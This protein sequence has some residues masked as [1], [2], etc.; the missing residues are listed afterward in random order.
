MGQIYERAQSDIDVLL[1]I[2]KAAR[3]DLDDMIRRSEVR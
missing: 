1:E 2:D 3:A